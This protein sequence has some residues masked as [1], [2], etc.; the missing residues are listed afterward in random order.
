MEKKNQEAAPKEESP[1]K[2]ASAAK[3]EWMPFNE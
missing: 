2:P 1:A 3:A